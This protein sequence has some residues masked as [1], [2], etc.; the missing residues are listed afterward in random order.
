MTKKKIRSLV[1]HAKITVK[2]SPNEKT[3]CIIQYPIIYGRS[4]GRS[5]WVEKEILDM[6]FLW[7]LATKK[8]AGWIEFDEDFLSMLKEEGVDFPEK[9]QGENQ[10]SKFLDENEKTKHFLLNYFKKM[11]TSSHGV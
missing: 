4:G 11:L 1:R 7:D 2:K 8:G 3:N 6:M 5:I 10:L 9:I